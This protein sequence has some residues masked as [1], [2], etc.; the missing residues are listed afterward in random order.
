M[1]EEEAKEIIRT[2]DYQS[3]TLLNSAYCYLEAIKK[4]APLVE[5]LE[6]GEEIVYEGS[7]HYAIPCS[8]IEDVL[9]KYQEEK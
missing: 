2:K 1:R 5:T 4:A 8:I 7:R 9:I 6:A 3:F